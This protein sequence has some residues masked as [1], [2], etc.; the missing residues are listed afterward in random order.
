MLTKEQLKAVEGLTED[1]IS[2]IANLSK[3]D[4]DRIVGDKFKEFHDRVDGIL[5]KITGKGKPNGVQTTANLEAVLQELSEKASAAGNLDQLQSKLQTVERERDDLKKKIKEG[6]GDE[7]LKGEIAKLEQRLRDKE[8]EV[9]TLKQNL[10]KEKN[11]L[12]SELETVKGQLTKTQIGKEIDS[13][14]LK[15]GVKFKDTIPETVLQETLETRRE[16]LLQGITT[17]QIDN[18]NGGKITVFRDEKGEIL[19]NPKNAFN[20]YTAGE[21]YFDR[22][23][24]L[25]DDGQQKTGAGTKGGNGKTGGLSLDF[26]SATTQVQANEM[27]VNHLMEAEGLSKLD[28]NLAERQKEVYLENKEAIDALPVR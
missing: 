13:Y 2:A 27:I 17:D 8:S 16:R 28:P 19:R 25:I 1:Q 5:E 22:V 20:P 9:S 18:G 23:K 7:T 15:Q 21:L 14:L 4:E 12:A 3:A 26:S 6:A 10:T 11:D 24:D